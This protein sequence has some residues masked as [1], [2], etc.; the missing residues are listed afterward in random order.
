[1]LGPCLRMLATRVTVDP[2]QVAA[3]AYPVR[4]PMTVARMLAD[5]L[6]TEQPVQNAP[7]PFHGFADRILKRRPG[8]RREHP[9]IVRELLSK[10]NPK[11]EMGP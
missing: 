2:H 9:D 1:M 4:P 10:S 11:I 6:K 5:S 7:N 3:I 8:E